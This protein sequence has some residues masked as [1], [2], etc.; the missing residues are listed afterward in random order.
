MKEFSIM[1]QNPYYETER[2]PGS[3]RHEIFEGRTGNRNK[4]IE[5]GLVIFIMPYQHRTGNASIH[6]NPKQWEWLKVVAQ[7]TWQDYYNKTEE[8]FRLRYGK[9]YL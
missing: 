9:N 5:D 2:F 8:E 7:K 4:S 3:E 6:L 1:P